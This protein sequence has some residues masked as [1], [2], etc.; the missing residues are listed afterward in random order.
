MHLTQRPLSLSAF[1][2]RAGAEPGWA[3][4]PCWALITTED[5]AIPPAGQRWMAERAGASVSDVAS[6]HAVMVSH[7]EAVTATVLAAVEAVG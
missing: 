4:R 2:G 6:S 3:S 5:N 7:P 1:G